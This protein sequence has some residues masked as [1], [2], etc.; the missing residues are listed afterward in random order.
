MLV[1]QPFP[2]CFILTLTSA[3]T[4]AM[5]ITFIKDHIASKKTD[6]ILFTQIQNTLYHLCA[7]N[8]NF[9]AK[10]GESKAPWWT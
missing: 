8:P 9:D 2:P 3:D 1:S 6:E 5:I 10:T 7:S 4:N